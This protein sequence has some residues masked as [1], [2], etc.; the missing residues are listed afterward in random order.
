MIITIDGPTASGKST[1]ASLLAKEF[2]FYY[3]NSGFLYRAVAYLLI[4]HELY[5]NDD[6]AN[7]FIRWDLGIWRFGPLFFR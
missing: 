4:N 5:K 2:G 7:R 1:V 6:L 3:L